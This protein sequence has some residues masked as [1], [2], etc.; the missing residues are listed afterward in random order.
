MSRFL[1]LTLAAAMLTLAAAPLA[2][3]ANERAPTEEETAAVRAQAERVFAEF[4]AP[5][6]LS[7][8]DA[9]TALVALLRGESVD[10]AA[11]VE[12]TKFLRDLAP[13][14]D[15][16]AA[17]GFVE[18][19]GVGVLQAEYAAIAREL[20]GDKNAFD[21][22]VAS[23]DL[24]RMTPA[25]IRAAVEPLGLDPVG[26]ADNA[27]VVATQL[28]T[29]ATTVVED[30]R[31]GSP[32]NVWYQEGWDYVGVVTTLVY[33]TVAVTDPTGTLAPELLPHNLR[34][35]AI[36]AN[37]LAN[38]GTVG[39]ATNGYFW[40]QLDLELL[41]GLALDQHTN[42]DH[43]LLQIP[44]SV[45]IEVH[46]RFVCSGWSCS[47]DVWTVTL[48]PETL[49]AAE[50]VFEHAFPALA[51]AF[52]TRAES[53]DLFQSVYDRLGALAFAKPREI[54]SAA[55]YAD[56]PGL[57]DLSTQAPV[58]TY[59]GVQLPQAPDAPAEVPAAPEVP[60]LPVEEPATPVEAPTVHVR[61]RSDFATLPAPV[62]VTGVTAAHAASAVRAWNLNILVVR[63][64]TPGI[65]STDVV[66]EAPAS[67]YYDAAWHFTDGAGNV[68]TTDWSI[69]ED[70]A[71]EVLPAVP[72]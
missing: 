56:T 1:T 25:E 24:V 63:W 20:V 18:S 62:D 40:I 26:I 34:V 51:G 10:E 44:A 49:M 2:F 6:G 45:R 9:Q 61:V 69:L 47:F 64:H 70:V 65:G 23:G 68:L 71:G 19:L 53:M 21:A 55:P 4:A 14:A 8:E 15:D 58:V 38:A 42:V 66:P 48:T 29:T 35:T 28:G 54:T 59:F 16:G 27:D 13:A 30:L 72:A 57:G 36:D 37:L 3:A 43:L 46:Y 32:R 31:A 11:R 67:F 17:N 39:S 33:L 5:S 12:V 41:A 7:A 22:L 52:P 60:A 50:P